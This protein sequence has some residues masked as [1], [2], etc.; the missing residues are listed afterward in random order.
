MFEVEPTDAASETAH[1][2]EAA[3]RPYRVETRAIEGA[4]DRADRRRPARAGASRR[5]PDTAATREGGRHE[6]PAPPSERGAD[7][8]GRRSSGRRTKRCFVASEDAQATR[9]AVET[10]NEEFQATNEELETLNEELTASVE[11]LR[12]ANEDLATRT[13]RAQRP[14]ERARAAEAEPPG[15][16]RSSPIHPG[17][18]RRRGRRGRPRRPDRGRP[19]TPTIGSSVPR[20]AEIEPEDA[21]GL[22]IR[23]GRAG[24]SGGPPEARRF[25]MEFAVT[26]PGGTRRWFEAV[27]EPLT[28]GDRTWGGVLAIRDLSER[29]MRLSLERLMAAAGHELKTP[30]AALHGYLQLVERHLG[31][32]S[33]EQART[34]AA[35]ALAQTRQVGELIERLFDVSRIQAGRLELVHRADRSRHDRA[36]GRRGCRDAPQ[37]TD[38][39]VLD[40]SRADHRQGRCRSSGAGIRQPALQRRRARGHV[41]DHRRGIEPIR[42][43]RRRRSPRS[44]PRDRR[45]RAAAAVPAVYA[46]G[47]ASRRP[48]WAW[49]STWRARS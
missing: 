27:A 48:A 8:P 17:Q 12:V 29:T 20:E 47:A 5:R 25:R 40:D 9:E 36:P 22:P 37:R 42:L 11:E 13:D 6:R 3:V 30:V 33:S 15:G 31:P 41:A 10:V 19:T 1:F 46:A 28:A 4:V 16:A 18:P 26:Q 32:D 45:R 14:D 24:R 21:A 23:A 38:Y 35:R 49:V 44:R 39:P 34:Y 2:V 43:G 7:R